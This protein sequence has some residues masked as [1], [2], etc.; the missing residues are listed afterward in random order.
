MKKLL[1]ILTFISFIN[2]CGAEATNIYKVYNPH[3][4]KAY[5]LT[6]GTVTIID[7]VFLFAM[8]KDNKPYCVLDGDQMNKRN[9]L[10]GGKCTDYNALMYSIYNHSQLDEDRYMYGFREVKENTFYKEALVMRANRIQRGLEF[11]GDRYNQLK[12]V[13]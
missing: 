13:Q 2:M 4:N 6:L 5:F 7:N 11:F 1:L 9:N 10:V 8:F 3:E 12:E